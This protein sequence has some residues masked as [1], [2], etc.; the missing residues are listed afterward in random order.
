M[1]SYSFILASLMLAY[2]RLYD[3]SDNKSVRDES[4]GAI[5]EA[6]AMISCELSKEL[7]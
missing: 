5:V 4:S 7:A 1:Q 6:E 2:W 3:L